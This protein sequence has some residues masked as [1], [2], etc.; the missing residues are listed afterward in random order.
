MTNCFL[1]HCHVD[2]D[3]GHSY[4]SPGL[5]HC[6][7]DASQ[8]WMSVCTLSWCAVPSVWFWQSH[9]KSLC[10]YLLWN[11]FTQGPLEHKW[12][13]TDCKRA[14]PA[15]ALCQ[16]TQTSC[17][18]NAG[19]AAVCLC[20]L[21]HNVLVPKAPMRCTH[22]H[23]G[24]VEELGNDSK[25]G[26]R[27]RATGSGRGEGVS[28]GCDRRSARPQGALMARG[29]PSSCGNSAGST[30]DPRATCCWAFKHFGLACLWHSQANPNPHAGGGDEEALLG[31]TVGW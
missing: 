19:G 21:L 17:A 6:Q 18:P 16:A 13:S 9:L 23:H 22:C 24:D 2:L 11:C 31:H 29:R 20:G 1:R 28:A 26:A 5:R 7:A 12:H 14:F 3:L 8:S 10:G 4:N 15:Q 27:W 25:A 30:A